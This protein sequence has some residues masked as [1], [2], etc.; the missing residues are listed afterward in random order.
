MLQTK[1]TLSSWNQVGELSS[2]PWHRCRNEWKAS[3]KPWR[4]LIWIQICQRQLNPKQRRRTY[5]IHVQSILEYQLLALYVNKTWQITTP[6]TSNSRDCWRLKSLPSRTYSTAR[7]MVRDTRDEALL[8]H[9]QPWRRP[10]YYS[11]F[12][13][14][15]QSTWSLSGSISPHW[16]KQSQEQN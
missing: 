14:C 7:G 8:R 3:W 15:S 2:H 10:V 4:H 6:E 5:M 9:Q 12:V 16:Y 13:P 1:T 11:C